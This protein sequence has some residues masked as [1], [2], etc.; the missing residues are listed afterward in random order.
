MFTGALWAR[1]SPMITIDEQKSIKTIEDIKRFESKPS[2][3][4]GVFTP[5]ELDQIRAL[6]DEAYTD[7][8]RTAEK[9]L[10]K[11]SEPLGKMAHPNADLKMK[12]ESIIKP[13]LTNVF[14]E[15]YEMEF[16]FHRNLF[17]YGIHTDSGYD[18]EEAIYKQGIIPLDVF[19]EKGE[20]YTVIFDQKCYHSISYPKD[21]ETIKSLKTEELKQIKDWSETGT[22]KEEL[23]KYWEPGTDQFENFNKLSIALPFK[24]KQGDMAI[25]DRA[26]LHCSSD[27][28]INSIEGKSG[29]MWISRRI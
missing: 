13:K 26:H 16:S 14:T 17:P 12:L 25:W 10:S 23:S 27:F 21:L 9:L 8:K 5:S 29:L 2:V 11:E 4:S 20:V 3:L 19:P 18:T 6:R 28:S 1:V 15:R 22:S 7:H 24:W